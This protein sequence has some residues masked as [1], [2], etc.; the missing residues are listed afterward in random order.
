MKRCILKITAV[1][2]LLFYGWASDAQVTGVKY[3][4]K[5]N[6]TTAQFDMHLVITGGSAT[7]LTQRIQFNTQI[8]FV[9]PKGSNINITNRY[10]PRVPS[11]SEPIN[12]NTFALRSHHQYDFISFSP[13]LAPMSIYDILN[14]GDTI[15]LFSF[16]VTPVPCKQEVRLFE[17]STDPSSSDPIMNGVD[18]NNGF[19]I[20]GVTQV[21]TGNII[22]IS[23]ITL[24]V[25][26]LQSNSVCPNGT[27]QATP[28][29]GGT[30]RSLNP[31]VATISSAGLITGVNPGSTQFL[32]RESGTGCSSLPT[33][34]LTVKERSVVSLTGPNSIC[35]GQTSFVN[36]P[37]SGTWASN[38]NAIAIISNSG[39]I[40]GISAGKTQ[41]IFT[42]AAT[43]C[44]SLPTDTFTVLPQPALTFTGPTSI[45]VGQTTSISP[46]TGGTWSSGNPLVA[47]IH[48]NTGMISG[49]SQGI[50]NFTYT[51]V[52][53]CTSVSTMLVINPRPSVIINGSTAICIG[54]TSTLSPTS[55]G[56]WTSNNNAIAISNGGIITGV[57][58]GTTQ[59]IFT[60]TATG[61][62][63]QP[64]ETLTVHPRPVVSFTGPTIMCAGQT[65]QVTPTSG[66]T[67][68]SNN[69]S[70]ATITNRGD[71]T[72]FSAGKT[73]FIF[74]EVVTGCTSLPTDTLTV[75]P[76]PIIISNRDS[77]NLNQIISLTPST[78][79]TWT[80]NNPD[81]LEITGSSARG[82][83]IG[84]ATVYFTDASTGCRSVNKEIKV[85]NPISTIVGYAFRDVNGN[86]LFDSSTDSP[87]P[88]CAITISGLNATYY[89]DPTGYYHISVS[90]GSYTA[91][92]K[93]PY[94]IWIANTKTRNINATSSITY[95]LV[96]F[97][98]VNQT[99][100]AIASINS[101]NF[102]CGTTVPFRAKALN[103]SSQI[104]NGYLYLDLDP[105]VSVLSTT[106]FPVGSNDHQLIWSVQNILPGNSYESNVMIEIPTP[107]INNDSLHFKARIIST[108]GDTLSVFGYSDIYTCQTSNGKILSWPDRGL[109]NFTFRNEPIDYMIRFENPAP[110][111]VQKV[112]IMSMLDEKIDLES[113][114]IK[115]ASHTVSSY[116]EN[117]NLFFEFNDINLNGGRTDT[118]N[119]YVTFQVKFFPNIPEGSTI[120]NSAEITFDG[121]YAI[122]TNSAMNTIVS[123]IPSGPLPVTWVSFEAKPIDKKAELIWTVNNEINVES[124]EIEHSLGGI[125]F[126]N[127]GLMP[128][129]L[130]N[131]QFVEEYNF[132]HGE[133]HDG[134][135]YYRIKQID[136]DGRYTYSAIKS[137][138][139]DHDIDELRIFP[140]PSGDVIWLNYTVENLHKQHI[141]ILNSQGKIVRNLPSSIL[142]DKNIDISGLP[143]G[144]YILQITNDK[145]SSY[146]KFVKL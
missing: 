119:G 91:T 130:N 61:C 38:N 85:V 5:Y 94:G 18:A 123:A 117:G 109:E 129:M 89:T 34:P 31:T 49:V 57:A 135:N 35:I 140:N 121:A 62:T 20:G 42:D 54:S 77:V 68:I 128:A 63:S 24:P 28:T 23:P 12:W 58:E 107:I 120:N 136:Y 55:G 21:Y 141:S 100:S 39:V 98:P 9:V 86:G 133:P 126:Y 74:T 134:V 84:T 111:R 103:N 10:Q 22:T 4:L 50:A 69:P 144:S 102:K 95:V 60:E 43:G 138:V 83:K 3:M 53:G 110:T 19:T 46:T 47:T 93:V 17:N 143:S 104:L 15:K 14:I 99:L 16:S 11:T 92:F 88:N 105:K 137:V 56:I 36:R 124:Y 80:S 13:S 41:F 127:L 65:T 78:G 82:L 131:K 45:C 122:T 27:I 64:T 51:S 112:K 1:L 87:L 142:E 7:T 25:T 66:G 101:P 6:D 108:N 97:N 67:W 44:M 114:I 79:G 76:L 70:I 59:F 116:R 75:H 106:P 29:T 32:F 71:I 125:Q 90:P 113:I 73:Q 139:I 48:P 8:T 146:S 37:T 30:W 115:D 2:F 52:A 33:E 145:K 96:G 81:I 132:L 40:T 26:A 72:G 118:K